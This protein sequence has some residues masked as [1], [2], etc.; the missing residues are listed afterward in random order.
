[1]HAHIRTVKQHQ[2]TGRSAGA[3][4]LLLSCCQNTPWQSVGPHHP[5]GFQPGLSAGV[6]PTWNYVPSFFWRRRALTQRDRCL[7]KVHWGTTAG[8]AEAMGTSPTIARAGVLPRKGFLQR[9]LLTMARSSAE[10][11]SA[12]WACSSSSEEDK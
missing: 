5:P 3:L 6:T 12:R 1:M 4:P 7:A 2:S 9:G 8:A 10:P 11:S